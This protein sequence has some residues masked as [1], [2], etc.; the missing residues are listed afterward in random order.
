[1]GTVARSV[2][3]FTADAVD[4]GH[5]AGIAA[6]LEP[7]RPRFPVVVAAAAHDAGEMPPCASPSDDAR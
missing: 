6:S 1:M 7:G 2:L 4:F 5:E 3:H